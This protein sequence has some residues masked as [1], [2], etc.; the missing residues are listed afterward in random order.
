[1]PGVVIMVVWSIQWVLR[2]VEQS[3][4]MGAVIHEWQFVNQAERR[5]DRCQASLFGEEWLRLSCLSNCAL[6]STEQVAAFCRSLHEMKPSDPSPSPQDSTGPQLAA[7]RQLTDADKLRKVICEL[8]ETE[9]TYVKVRLLSPSCTHPVVTLKDACW[10][11]IHGCRLM[12]KPDH[13]HEGCL[14]SPMELGL[15]SECYS[16]LLCFREACLFLQQFI[17][18]NSWLIDSERRWWW[19]LSESSNL[20]K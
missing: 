20:S 3:G 19:I 4:E 9:R 17:D 5:Q 8:L 18:G 1:M 7:M 6:K 14:V 12:T 13:G 11:F 16:F 2:C 10:V 15:D